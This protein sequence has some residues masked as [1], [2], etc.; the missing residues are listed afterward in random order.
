MSDIYNAAPL[1]A[2]RHPSTYSHD[3]R[4]VFGPLQG[5]TT[6]HGLGLPT[7]RVAENGPDFNAS[8]ARGLTHGSHTGDG[9]VQ[10]TNDRGV[11]HLAQKTGFWQDGDTCAD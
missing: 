2:L 10:Q 1:Q 11:Y 5:G 3:E 6:G 9:I 7:G 4:G 8:W